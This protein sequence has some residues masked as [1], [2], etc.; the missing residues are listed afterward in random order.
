MLKAGNTD[1]AHFCITTAKKTAV[2]GNKI[3]LNRPKYLD[4]SMII[5]ELGAIFDENELCTDV[6]CLRCSSWFQSS[7]VHKLV[8]FA[9]QYTTELTKKSLLNFQNTDLFTTCDK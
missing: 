3:S 4:M 1:L 7:T 6:D 2:N 5:E 8:D 9:F